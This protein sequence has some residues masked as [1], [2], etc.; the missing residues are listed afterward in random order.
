MLDQ[1]GVEY[2]SSPEDIAANR[3]GEVSTGQRFSLEGQLDTLTKQFRL[4]S[5]AGVV[6]TVLGGVIVSPLHH[7]GRGFLLYLGLFAACFGLSLAVQGVHT[8]VSA[9]AVRRALAAPRV[10]T[11]EG[12]VHRIRVTSKSG[13][14][15]RVSIGNYNLRLPPRLANRFPE[16]QS[17]RVHAL[18]SSGTFL[19]L[20]RTG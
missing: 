15:Y 2:E 4:R 1:L 7:G 14:S 19:S 6:L 12:A 20:E 13:G 16:G 18:A 10:E 9:G 17:V 3:R 8:L 5:M 11:F